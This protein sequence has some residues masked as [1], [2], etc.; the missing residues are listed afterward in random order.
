MAAA[1]ALKIC[2]VAVILPSA[3]PIQKHVEITSPNASQIAHATRIVRI[4]L[5]DMGHNVMMLK[6]NPSILDCAITF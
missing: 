3:I 1:A 4:S 5:W 6:K 2:E